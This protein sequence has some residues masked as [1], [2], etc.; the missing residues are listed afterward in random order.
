MTRHKKGHKKSKKTHFGPERKITGKVGGARLGVRPDRVTGRV[1]DPGGK[2][3]CSEESL[4]ELT[5]ADLNLSGQGVARRDGM[6]YFVNGLLLGE[7]APCRLLDRRKNYA[8]AEPAAKPQTAA[9]H[10]RQSRP[11]SAKTSLLP[12]DGTSSF[13]PSPDRVEPACSLFP[14]CGGCDLQHLTYEAE[15]RWKQKQVFDALVRIGSFAEKTVLDLLAPVIGMAEPVAYRNKMQFPVT[16][17]GI[18]F[19]QKGSRSVVDGAC[20]PA[21]LPP[22]DLV[23]DSF[24]NY[25][26]RFSLSTYDGAIGLGLVRHLLVRVGER[27][28]E[29]MVCPIVTEPDMPGLGEWLS[30]LNGRL[31]TIGYSLTSA[32]ININRD[33]RN[34]ILGREFRH[35]FGSDVIYEEVGGIRYRISPASFFQV[36]TK[37]AEV[38][39]KQVVK[40]AGVRPTDTVFDLYGGTGSIALQL[41]G[42]CQ[43]VIGNEM[44]EAAVEDARKNARDNGILNARFVT[45]KAE[46]VV[47]DLYREGVRADVVVVDP[48]RKGCDGALLDTLCKMQ[49]RRLVYVSCNPATLARDLKILAD[50]GSFQLE[51][52]QP[53]DMFPRTTHVETVVLMSRES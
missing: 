46:A 19:Y 23:R 51:R 28:R 45:G 52:V 22:A 7:T 17:K 11:R 15:L 5:A 8:V 50:E 47:P 30:D 9:A 31:K 42:F 3:D 10:S 25:M 24:R 43:Q 18:G 20:C 39:F 49:P 41:A 29:C 40:F 13:S 32:F 38:L 12:K 2:I 6:V 14:A 33:R 48:P 4:I 35:C 26:K 34:R 27:T 21:G 16:A 1:L 44:V 53:V 36:N 37:Q